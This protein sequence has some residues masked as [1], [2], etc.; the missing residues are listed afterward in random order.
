VFIGRKKDVKVR[1]VEEGYKGKRNY[2]TQSYQTTSS[3][4]SSIKFF[5]PL[6]V[7]HSTNPLENQ[8]KKNIQ[9]ELTKETKNNIDVC[10]AFKMKLLQLF[11]VG[12]ITFKDIL[13]INFNPLSNHAS[14][15]GGV[16]V[17]EFG[18]KKEKV[19][20]VTMDRLYNML[21]QAKYFPIKN[22]SGLRKSNSFYRF[23]EVIGHNIDECEDF[24]QKVI[25]MM[26]CGL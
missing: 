14:S 13:N 3:Q 2:Q 23:C 4:V 9:G 26:T 18:R 11:K 8:N 21:V 7:S 19:L 20:K 10:P 17:M 1:N 25:Q 5:K 16:N 15:S 22:E 12:W 6:S 24:H